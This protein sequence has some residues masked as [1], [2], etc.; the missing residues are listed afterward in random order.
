[1]G[2]GSGKALGMPST[3]RGMHQAQKG[4]E[5]SG[6][7]GCLERGWD[8]HGLVPTSSKRASLDLSR[9]SPAQCLNPGWKRQDFSDLLSSLQAAQTL[10]LSKHKELQ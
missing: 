4:L 1:M 10:G 8:P 3:V 9:K 5:P 7:A 6:E 2:A